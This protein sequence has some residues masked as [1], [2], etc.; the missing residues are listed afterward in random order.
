MS[1]EENGWG[2]FRSHI[3]LQRSQPL[4]RIAQAS[5]ANYYRNDQ[6]SCGVI[7]PHL[8]AWEGPL[9]SLSLGRSLGPG[10]MKGMIV[11]YTMTTSAL[12]Q[13][14]RYCT[15]TKFFRRFLPTVKT[16]T[17]LLQI[18]E[19]KANHVFQELLQCFFLTPSH[20]RLKAPTIRE[21]SMH[22]V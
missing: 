1:W 13:S 3:S 18:Q 8:Q 2:S 22:A 17:V 16:F 15:I 4:R 10:R 7:H 14:S 21:Q 12:L 19:F 9:R 6:D 20:P 11:R 5:Q